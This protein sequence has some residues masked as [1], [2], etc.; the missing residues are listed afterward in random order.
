[1]KNPTNQFFK[2]VK[3]LEDAADLWKKARKDPSI[4]E[5]YWFVTS[6]MECAPKDC[7][8]RDDGLWE[9]KEKIN[10][11]CSH[12]GQ[13][14]IAIWRLWPNYCC[15]GRPSYP[16]VDT[17]RE[18]SETEKILHTH[19]GY[20]FVWGWD[21]VILPTS[22]CWG[23]RKGPCWFQLRKDGE[24]IV[25]ESSKAAFKRACNPVFGIA[26]PE[27]KPKRKYTIETEKVIRILEAN[28]GHA[29]HCEDQVQWYYKPA[30]KLKYFD[31]DDYWN[32]IFRPARDKVALE[33]KRLTDG[34]LDTLFKDIDM[35][36]VRFEQV[37]DFYKDKLIYGTVELTA[38]GC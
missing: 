3:A 33:I 2:K 23:M 38:I 37:A 4:R 17:F 21:E 26:N 24:V 22:I 28:Y 25:Q 12:G 5:K 9:K 6:D 14:V 19:A 16:K 11:H 1:M 18:E 30:D 27:P 29:S 35:T 8:K 15:F 34:Y 7:F 20:Q 32:P 10:T 36:L 31:G 13:I